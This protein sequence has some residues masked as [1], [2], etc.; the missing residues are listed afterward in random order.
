MQLIAVS[1]FVA[2]VVDVLLFGCCWAIV[3]FIDEIKF[4][5]QDLSQ[6]I[7]IKEKEPSTDLEIR[8]K[9]RDI[10]IFQGVTRELSLIQYFI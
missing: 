7:S 9:F 4:N 8:R 3:A 5:I 2:S 6:L 10:L 1:G